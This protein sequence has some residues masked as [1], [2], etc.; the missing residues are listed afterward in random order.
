MARTSK[1]AAWS[2]A[3]SPLQLE[4]S[5]QAPWTRTTVGFACP[6]AR[7]VVS[8]CTSADSAGALE[9]ARGLAAA[10]LAE[11]P[12][13]AAAAT[14]TTL[15]ALHGERRL[16]LRRGYRTVASRSLVSL[17]LARPSS[18]V[19]GWIHWPGLSRR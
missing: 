13:N 11:I 1:P 14:A 8:R 10:S 9:A 5:A 16:R 3:T 7:H 19:T 6:G 18:V 2:A 12:A 4:A 17:L 15:M